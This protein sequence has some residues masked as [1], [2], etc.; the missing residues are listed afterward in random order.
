[1]VLPMLVSSS[2]QALT[3]DEVFEK[4]TVLTMRTELA[5]LW[6]GRFCFEGRES[7]VGSDPKSDGW[8]QRPDR[9]SYLC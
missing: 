1:M 3:L 2:L 5:P 6:P 8:G 9:E 7:G 4:V